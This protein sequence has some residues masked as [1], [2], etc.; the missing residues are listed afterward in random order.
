MTKLS[1][2]KKYQSMAGHLVSL[3]ETLNSI[4]QFIFCKTVITNVSIGTTTSDAK[5]YGKITAY[6]SDETSGLDAIAEGSS[7]ALYQALEKC[8]DQRVPLSN[9]MYFSY[10]DSLMLVRP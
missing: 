8:Y 3:D 4:E 1:W 5:S 10:N 7:G 9:Y 6:G 2:I